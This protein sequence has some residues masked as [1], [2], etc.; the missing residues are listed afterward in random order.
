MKL[1]RK[2]MLMS[3]TTILVPMLIIVFFAVFTIFRNT[4]ISQ[5]EYL[6]S[7]RDYIEEEMSATERSYFESIRMAAGDEFIRAK[8]YVYEKYWNSLTESLRNYDLG[9]LSSMIEDKSQNEDIQLLAVY[10]KD[11]AAFKLVDYYGEDVHLPERVEKDAAQKD[12][13][14][15]VY[16]KYPEGIFLRLIYPVFSEGKLVGLLMYTRSYDES[17]V[18]EIT[19]I[20]G[21]GAAL[22]S[23][24]NIL[25][26]SNRVVDGEVLGLLDDPGESSR[27][28][29][30]LGG[31]TY[32]AL[33]KDFNLGRTALGQLVFYTERTNVLS[34]N[35][36][37]FIQLVM[38]SLV[39][40]LIP[41]AAF[42]V[43]EVRLI[44]SINQL[45]SATSDISAGNYRTWVNIVADDEIG[46]LSRNFNSM[47][48]TLEKNRSALETQ[49]EELALKNSYIDAVFQSLKINIIVLDSEHRIRVLSRNAQSRL[50]LGEDYESRD[51]LSVSPFREVS[52]ILKEPL[53]EAFQIGRFSRLYSVSLGNASYEAD[54][55]PV[56]GEAQKVSAVVLILNNITEKMEM[57]RALM[58]SDRLASIGS[59]AA[60][61]AHEINNPLGII[62]NHVQ[63][64][65]SGALSGEQEARFIERIETEIKRVSRMIN[66]LLKFSREETSAAERLNPSMVLVEVVGLLDPSAS[67]ESVE[68]FYNG[69]R[70]IDSSADCYIVNLSGKKIRIYITDSLLDG[71]VCCSRDSLKQIFFNLIKNS[72]E[73][74]E[75]NDGIIWCAM[76][77]FR[78]ALR[79]EISDNG[80]GVPDKESV[81][82]LF[83][84]SRKT[85]SG[86]GLPL[87]RTLM[88][89][90]GGS[91]RLEDSDSGGTA[92]VL[93]FPDKGD[94]FG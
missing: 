47:V 53:S 58:R 65:G 25:I 80:C 86:M 35:R 70:M 28:S 46:M 42:S 26:S 77:H 90:A 6:E 88:N 21:I 75:E 64:I 16:L 1:S 13:N 48:N 93:N 29:F 20:Y 76:E 23:D 69:S 73:S 10:R 51:F 78:G 67:A 4:T 66:N 84:S 44:R 43:K 85:G 49:N 83:Y 57:E 22:V 45:L 79:I 60:G 50:E 41:V 74:F 40:I 34:E 12:Y 5:W 8:L 15:I 61:F 87:C 72:F 19:G 30:R 36:A 92:V 71:S 37:M 54:F 94:C 52:D 18:E 89:K 39:C 31:K 59:L 27:R 33:I 24:G 55:Y 3:V 9:S 91:I 17:F 7:V 32:T 63:L 81:F 38:L 2:L 14:K 62:L 56:F 82:E 68:R 11:G